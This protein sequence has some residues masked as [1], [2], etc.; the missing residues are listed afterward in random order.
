MRVGIDIGGMSVKIGLVDQDGQIVGKKVIPTRSDVLPPEEVVNGIADGVLELLKE[1]EVNVSDCVSIGVACPGTVDG[2][3]GVVLYS[4][5]IAWENVPMLDILRKKLPVPSYL[6]NDADAAAL[7]EVVA[8]A[9]K[10]KDSALLLTLGTGVG[11]GVMAE[12]D[13]REGW[14][15]LIYDVSDLLLRFLFQIWY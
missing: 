9:A 1:H 13:G 14:P 3:T 12:R 11:G 7:G 6:A 15:E 2:R 10:G 4:N 8:G 5:N